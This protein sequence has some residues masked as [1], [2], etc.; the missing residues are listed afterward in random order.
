MNILNLATTDTNAAGVACRNINEMLVQAGHKSVLLVKESGADNPGVI[1]LH[2][3]KKDSLVLHYYK[4]IEHKLQLLYRR[5]NPLNKEDKYSFHNLNE[6]KKHF[7]GAEILSKIQFKPDVILIFWVSDFVNSATMKELSDLTGAKILWLMTD[8]APLTGGCHYP[9]DCEGFHSD[10][11]NCPAILTAAKKNIAQL[12][13]AYKKSHIPENLELMS[14]SVSDYER[15]LKSSLFKGKKIHKLVAPIDENKFKPGNKAEAKRH[16]GI[17]PHKRAIFFGATS[18]GDPRKG[19]QYFL[20]A[21]TIVN[22]NR[23]KH[24]FLLLLA[25]KEGFEHFRNIGIT[26]K[27]LGYLNEE[28]L[29]KAYQAADFTVSPSL[30]D[31]GPMMVNQSVMCGT[32]MVT[33]NTGVAMDL[34]HTGETGYIAKLFDTADLAAGIKYMLSLSDDELNKISANCRNFALANITP[35]VYAEKLLHILKT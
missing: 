7:S 23:E 33:F 1:V 10:C 22:S 12:N 25:G 30:E 14:G 19:V 16:F 17:D 9:W 11:S 6:R 15:A 24:D 18:L 21:L 35:A 3:K 27:E 8:N 20:D 26:V 28:N 29:I 2:K 5:L 31:S 13:L 32:P 34:I 4:K